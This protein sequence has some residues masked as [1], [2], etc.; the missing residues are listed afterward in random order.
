MWGWPCHPHPLSQYSIIPHTAQFTVFT[1]SLLYRI[2]V[3]KDLREERFSLAYGFGESFHYVRT[4]RWN[5]SIYTDRSLWLVLLHMRFE[6]ISGYETHFRPQVGDLV[7]SIWDHREQFT[8]KLQLQVLLWKPP[9]CSSCF[10]IW[11]LFMWPVK[12]WASGMLLG[13]TLRSDDKWAFSWGPLSSLEGVQGFVLSL[14]SSQLVLPLP[15]SIELYRTHGVMKSKISAKFL[16]VP[17]LSL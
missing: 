9:F 7:F 5:G 4:S 1:F 8:F 3:W 13:H 17:T 11:A 14:L 10:Y 6:I 15:E 16:E 2:P 12:T